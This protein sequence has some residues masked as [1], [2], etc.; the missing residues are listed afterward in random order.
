MS[1]FEHWDDT[2]RE[3]YHQLME[4]KPSPAREPIPGPGYEQIKTGFTHDSHPAVEESLP[5]SH[6]RDG[7]FFDEVAT[8]KGAVARKE[9]E[10]LKLADFRN[11]MQALDT[12]VPEVQPLVLTPKHAADMRAAGSR[13]EGTTWVERNGPIPETPEAAPFG[14]SHPLNGGEVLGPE[15]FGRQYPEPPKVYGTS[16]NPLED[17]ANDVDDSTS[18]P[19]S[20]LEGMTD[21]ERKA[22][23]VMTGF[24]DYF[25]DAA[26]AVAN[27]SFVANE[28][29]NPDEEM[30]W[31]RS[32]SPDEF[33][34]ALRHLMQRGTVD[35]DGLRHTAKAAWRIMAALQ[36]ELEEAGE[37]TFP[38]GARL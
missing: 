3:A 18:E 36:K 6:I 21:T 24:L 20:G 1:R 14:S 16:P 7:S 31:A 37:G 11:A 38:R 4:P 25:P 8:A 5:L 10:G 29:H 26:L 33:N 35:K 30:H 27:V 34:T 9:R 17:W 28:Q 22:R 13:G 23:P 19:A 2:N 12:G 32:K 15:A